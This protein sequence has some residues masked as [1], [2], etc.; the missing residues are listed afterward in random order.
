MIELAAGVRVRRLVDD[1]N[2]LVMGEVEIDPD[3]F[4]PWHRHNVQEGIIVT[5]GE[6]DAATPDAVTHLSQ[7]MPMLFPGGVPHCLRNTGSGLLRAVFSFPAAEVTRDWVEEAS[8][9]SFAA[10]KKH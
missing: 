5:L 1:M 10:E 2:G 7:R 6:G 8:I 3:G 4:L 9:P